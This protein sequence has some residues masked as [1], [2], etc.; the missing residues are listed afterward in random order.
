MASSKLKP[1][2]THLLIL[3][4]ILGWTINSQAADL[5]AAH[6]IKI[7]LFP[8]DMTL[9][10]RN[11]IT[12]ETSE[13][14][15]LEFRLSDRATR[16]DARVNGE[17]RNFDFENGRLQLSLKPH[18]LS[19]KVQVAIQ[20]S[21]KFD[22]PVPVR[23]TNMDNPGFGVTATIS[24]EGTFLLAGAG[25]YPELVGS[26]TNYRVTI[27]APPGLIAVTAGRSLGHEIKNGKTVSD[28][29]VTYPVEGLSLSVAR[30]E[31]E[32][33]SVGDVTA[34]TYLLAH[35]QHLSAA[36]LEAT[37]GYLTLYSDLF[38]AYP[39]Q[40]FAVVENF[41]P[42]GYG[43]PSYTLLGG[44]VL[45]LPFIIG[46][47]LGHEIAH[48]W[49]GNGVIVD[50]AQGN[51]SEAL[52]TYVADY[53][54]K[55]MTSPEAALEHRRQW[56][57]N[58]STLVAPQR[59]FALDRFQSRYDP[60]TRTIGY[61]KG[62][63]VFHM[64][65]Q[66]LGE[67]A[68][69]GALRELYHTRLF[70]RTSWSDLQQAFETHGQRSMQDFFDQW[71]H[72]RGA[73]RFSL[74]GVRAEYTGDTWKVKGQIIQ[75]QPYFTFPL[76]LAL[77]T[78]KQSTLKQ[79]FVAGQTT[80]FELSADHQ[81]QRLIADQDN[82]I[83]RWLSPSEIPPAVNA[84]KSSPSILTV[85]SEK[86]DPQIRSAAEILTHSLGL[87]Y[88]KFVTENELDR[89]MLAE[90][91]ILV[92]GLPRRNDLLQKMPVRVNIQPDS[93]SLNKK[94]YQEPFDTFFGVFEHPADSNRI[95]ALFMPLSPQSAEMVARKITH[96][97]KYSYLAFQ[98]G[99]NLD[100]GIWPVETSPLVH[101]WEQVHE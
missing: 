70:K 13:T 58:Y 41:F 9:T 71:V 82:N 50:Y 94:L 95:A 36:Y 59:D 37:A 90:N 6:H 51:W 54:F 29:E 27:T 74:D 26:R 34:A 92:I 28:W 4:G 84:L 61:D 7:E 56:L 55:E 21:A 99:K 30:Y 101:E 100:K 65:R 96:Y 17:S 83:F 76:M 81:P 10:G 93:F 98:S 38:G 16:I 11:D 73:P 35:N 14:E 80:S 89:Q 48:C 22:D 33:K 78:R 68:F 47:S 57:R 42:T 31:V 20:Y 15:I 67:K 5:S 88:N 18:E 77:E 23:P 62:A 69:W 43:F 64:I 75:T 91:D 53:R 97:G 86:L 60:V 85:L 79:I 72:R 44:R 63:M 40:K 3:L 19:D 45:Q 12:I 87:K 1:C 24:D 25:W 52:T 46:T 32:E 2:L 39:F 66:T 49:W 8:A